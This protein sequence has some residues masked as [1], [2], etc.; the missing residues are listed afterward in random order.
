[1]HKTK[2]M[3]T[4]VIED[5]KTRTSDRNELNLIREWYYYNSRVRKRY[6]EVIS[7]LPEAELTRDRGASYPSILDI[8]THVLDAYRW[9]FLY[10]YTDMVHERKTLRGTGLGLDQIEKEEHKIDS[11]VNE[12]LK[13]LSTKDLAKAVVWHEVDPKGKRWTIKITMRDMLWQLVG[14]E[15]QHRG[16]LNALLWQID[17]DPPITEWVDFWT[18]GEQK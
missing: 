4:R 18:F 8:F 3:E 1:M 2:E 17:I 12:F 11:F 14:E 6:F 7:K 9:W 13:K 16:E 5:V 10:V 15:L